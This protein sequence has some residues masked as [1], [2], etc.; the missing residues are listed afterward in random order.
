MSSMAIAIL[1]KKTIKKFLKNSFFFLSRASTHHS[2]LICNS[3]ELKHKVHHFFNLKVCVEFFINDS[4]VFLPKFILLFDK[5]YGL[6]DFKGAST[7]NCES[8]K[9]GRFVTKIFF[10]DNV[11]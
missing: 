6:F 2:F 4:M 5:K 8:V 1:R 7:K 3:Y 9:K 10:S 11:E